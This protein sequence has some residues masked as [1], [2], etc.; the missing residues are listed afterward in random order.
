MLQLDGGGAGGQ[1]LR[2]GLTL[3][4]LTD[5][6]VRITDIRGSRPE[7][8]LKPQHETV[9]ETLARL[10]DAEVVGA[11]RGSTTVEFV[12]GP[13]RPGTLAVDI[14]TAGSVSLCF[15][16][17]LP[18]AARLDA[19]LSL[20]VTG[21]TEVTWSPPLSYLARVKLPL[22]RRHGVQAAV[23]RDRTG[24][25]PAG[26]GRATLHVGPST[27]APLDLTERGDPHGV[28]IHSIASGGL[29]DADV[30][31]RQATAVRE[32]LADAGLRVRHQTTTD[33]DTESPGSAVL[34]VLDYA[35]TRAGFSALGER[36]TPAEDVGEAAAIA[37]LS[38]HEGAAVVDRHMA[39]QLLVFLALSGGSLLVPA[40]TDHVGHSIA[41]LEEFGV[42]VDASESQSTVRLTVAD[43]L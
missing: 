26:G 29:R 30:A 2:T 15:D 4:V 27:P 39:D 42:S 10:C 36:G 28:D 38:F 18:L 14:G 12:P 9:V 6:P 37:A 24:F 11:D 35:G 19:P 32:R 31:G 21:G 13:L 33:A 8:G 20:T 41:L 43:P 16:A 40:L 34:A 1:F 22:L 7:P 17:V 5:T 25:Y 3:A 23:E